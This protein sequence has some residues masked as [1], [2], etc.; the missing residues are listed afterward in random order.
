MSRSSFARRFIPSALMAA[1][2]A[3]SGGDAAD[4][5]LTNGKVVT[6]DPAHPEA[7]AV[8]IRDG[9]ILAVGSSAEMADYVGPGTEVVDLAGRL[10]VPGFIEGHGHYMGLGHAQMI[11]D[12]TTAADWEEIVAMVAEAASAAAPGTWIQGRGWHQEKWSHTPEPSVEGNPVHGSLSAVSPDNP[13]LLGHA[14][15]HAAFANARALELA[16]I[17]AG[18]PDPEGGTIVRGPDGAPTGLLRETAQRIVSAVMAQTMN[19]RSDEE[20]WKEFAL[21][22][23]LAGRNALENGVTSFHDAGSGFATIDGLKRLADEGSLPVRLYVMVRRESND[24]MAEKL[25]AYRM[26]G[27][28]NDFLT[29]RAIKRQIDG[30]LGS[31]GA[32]L[33]EPYEDMPGS[34]G[35][36][37]ESV[38]DIEETA[39]IAIEAGYQVNTH[40][41]GD[42]ANR[43]VL[44][45][46]ERTF[47]G[48]D[49]ATDL[50]WRIEH[51]Q[52]VDP[53]DVDRFRQL[54]VI[55]AM[56]GVHATSDAPWVYRRLGAGRAESGAYLWRS[57]IDAGVV[58]TN[59]TDVPVEAISPVASFYASVVRRDRDGNEFFPSQRMTRMEALESYTINN[60]FA[61]FEEEIKGS[62]TPGKVADITVLDRDIMTV[63]EEEI[64]GARVD[65]TLV[66]GEIRF[67]RDG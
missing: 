41:I 4:M 19:A 36:V 26:V 35:L 61:A 2:V 34:T 20:K 32:W 3:C 50:R 30:A 7:E 51:A 18:T 1:I 31:H 66:G 27:Y 55:A 6:V 57:F 44:D 42:R 24:V 14:S 38:E 13:V 54:G 52:H 21:Q 8:A 12:L 67:R 43:E 23:E 59:G 16:G 63:P 33:L 40:A 11:L 60:A 49:D 62:I 25:P 9:R 28:G 5:V 58:V 17:G 29:V 37:L 15:G 53:D 65:L 56:Q 45:I 22:V 64:A 10:A 48:R 39:R 46:Y 47:A